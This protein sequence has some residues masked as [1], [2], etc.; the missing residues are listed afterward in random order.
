MEIF[1][2]L[3]SCCYSLAYIPQ[4][5]CQLNYSA[6]S[7]QSPLQNS[8]DSMLQLSWL[9]LLGTDYTENTVL[10]LLRVRI[11]CH[12]NMFRE[13][14]SRNRLHNPVYLKSAAPATGIVSWLLPA[15]GVQRQCFGRVKLDDKGWYCHG[16]KFILLT[17]HDP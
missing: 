5:H 10:L 4:L 6:F 2:L 1:Q 14:L 3:C 13:L 11:C 9:W 8:T 17:H 7:S 12:G 16:W 15:M